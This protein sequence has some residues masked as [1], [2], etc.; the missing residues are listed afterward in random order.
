MHLSQIFS[1]CTFVFDSMVPSSFWDS[2]FLQISMHFL[3]LADNCVGL[4]M[5]EASYMHLVTENRGI[6]YAIC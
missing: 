6:L 3:Y 4:P 1:I 5:L 2:N